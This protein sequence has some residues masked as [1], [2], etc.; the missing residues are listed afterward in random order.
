[1]LWSSSMVSAESTWIVIVYLV[2]FHRVEGKLFVNDVID[3]ITRRI[4]LLPMSFQQLQTNIHWE[5][6]DPYNSINN[7]GGDA[8]I[9]VRTSPLDETHTHGA[10]NQSVEK[11]NEK[12]RI[13]YFR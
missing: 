6:E 2:Q 7:E 12:K 13:K 4:M 9:I 5:R 3:L 10:L 11:L 8:N 1:M